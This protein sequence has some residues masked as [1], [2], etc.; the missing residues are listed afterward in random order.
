MRDQE[1]QTELYYLTHLPGKRHHMMLAQTK[2]IDIPNN[3]HL[4]MI[5]REHR[6]IDDIHQTLL[7]PLGHPH[8]GFGISCGSPEET[9]AIGVF[10]DTFEDGTDSRG[11]G[12]EI[13]GLFGWTG[14]KAELRRFGYTLSALSSA[15]LR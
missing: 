2:H 4:L 5:L 10:A 15:E 1:G 9:F 13:G 8:Q 12:S 14:V 6:I 11:K 3:H 7:V